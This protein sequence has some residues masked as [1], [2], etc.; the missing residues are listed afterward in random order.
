MVYFFFILN[1]FKVPKNSI[2]YFN[3]KENGYQIISI[4]QFLLIK[5]KNN[6]C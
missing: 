6:E 1:H 4:E 3:A 2:F 5:L